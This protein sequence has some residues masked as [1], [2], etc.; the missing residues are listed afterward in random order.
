MYTGS[1]GEDP[2]ELDPGTWWYKRSL[3]NALERILADL[4]K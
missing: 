1:L 4:E 3:I 2:D